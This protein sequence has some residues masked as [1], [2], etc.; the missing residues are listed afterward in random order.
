ML[1]LKYTLEAAAV[2]AQ[3]VSNEKLGALLEG[4][5][6][7]MGEQ[8]LVLDLPI[9]FLLVG[10]QSQVWAPSVGLPQQE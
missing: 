2:A 10:D 5:D 6:V 1:S 3:P 8:C 4:E 9:F 7:D